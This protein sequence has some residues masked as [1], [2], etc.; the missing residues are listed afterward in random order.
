MNRISENMK[1]LSGKIR[2]LLNT[3]K[4]NIPAGGKG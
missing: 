4:I 2:D 3:K 1:S